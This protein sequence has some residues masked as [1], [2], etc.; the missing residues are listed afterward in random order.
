MQGTRRSNSDTYDKS[1]SDLLKLALPYSPFAWYGKPWGLSEAGSKPVRTT[2]YN[3]RLAR[4]I[5][6][7]SAEVKDEPE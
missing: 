1:P 4:A 5:D 2:V 7:F 6:G 3:L